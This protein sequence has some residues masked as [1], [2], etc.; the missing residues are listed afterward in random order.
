MPD[1]VVGCGTLFL[2][3]LHDQLG[4]RIEDIINA[5]G[6]HLSN[7]YQNLTG[8]SAVNA[9]GEFQWTGQFTLSTCATTGLRRVHASVL[10]LRWRVFS[11]L[12]SDGVLRDTEVSWV[13]AAD[14][15]RPW[16]SAS[17]TRQSCP[18]AIRITSSH[19]DH[20]VHQ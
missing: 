8:D 14:G 15:A 9:F 2:F 16:S 18:L 12:R 1:P 6:G 7:V 3:Y 13:K 11:R 10:L 17:T 4:Y 19:P 5:G 20:P